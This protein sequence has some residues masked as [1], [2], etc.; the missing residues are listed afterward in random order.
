MRW[1][2]LVLLCGC[3]FNPNASTVSDAPSDHLP[4]AAHTPDARPPDA[5]QPDAPGP[6]DAMPDGRPTPLDCPS[7]YT[8]D[9][10]TGS[11]YRNSDDDS[12]SS[13]RTHHAATAYNQCNDDS[14]GVTHLAAI[15]DAAEVAALL[16]HLTAGN[17]Y[18]VGA[19]QQRDQAAPNV[20]WIEITDATSFYA[21]WRTGQP[22]DSNN[23]ENNS[24][25]FA[26]LSTDGFFDDFDGNTSRSFL[27][28]CDDK[29]ID[30]SFDD[31][32]N[33]ND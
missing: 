13:D 7:T 32:W 8:I 16:P 12:S 21:S 30:P 11:L 31:V 17:T 14:S 4:D 18:Y 28:E 10:G 6:V 15:D 22:D 20:G 2:A 26:V 27:C 33:D 19:T 29:P 23:A 9:V 3:G 5:R 1:L 24:Q 25:N